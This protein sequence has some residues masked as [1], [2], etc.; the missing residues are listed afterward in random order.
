MIL[1]AVGTVT[2]AA[3]AH[4]VEAF[5]VGFLPCLKAGFLLRLNEALRFGGFQLHGRLR[6]DRPD[7]LHCGDFQKVAYDCPKRCVGDVAISTLHPEVPL[8]QGHPVLA[9][10]PF[11][12]AVPSLLEGVVAKACRLVTSLR[13]GVD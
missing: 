3:L 10:F 8:L 7:L 1:L 12:V 2:P 13:G 4:A 5:V 11:D 9:V 6:C